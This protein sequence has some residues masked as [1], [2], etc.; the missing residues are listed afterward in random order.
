MRNKLVFFATSFA[1][2]WV[3][4]AI[5]LPAGWLLGALLTGII[6]S[7]F[8]EKLIF[9][10]ELFT[11][12]LALVG[13]VIGFMVVP[14]EVWEY[15]TLLPAFLLTLTLTLIGGI[16]L[17]K[18]F[19]KWTKL[20]GNTA[21]FC[22]LPGGASEVIALSERYQADQRIVAAFHT[23]RITLFVFSV[24]L[25]V[26]IGTQS[27]GVDLVERQ[28]ELTWDI[29]LVGL[30][31]LLAVGVFFVSRFL[32]FPGAPMFLAIILG[33]SVHQWI[34]PSYSMPNIVMGV[35]Q[36]LIGS[37]IGMRFDRSTLNE[38]K[39]IGK[40]SIVTLALYIAM[41]LGLAF[42]FFILSPLPFYTTLLAIV[43]AG[44][45]E[46][47]STAA[48]LEMDATVVATLQM[49]RVLALFLALPFLIRWFAQKPA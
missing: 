48:T 44:A 15:R 9:R 34:V 21:F 49:L 47:A 46:M 43:P 23:A 3:M 4:Q 25:I 41:S 2:G 13:I 10:S 33:F 6:W 30:A 42:T 39:R 45:A 11:L 37:V 29:A 40:P 27:S 17:G 31:F 14:E 16:A 26:G 36:V 19:G 1:V 18:F 20:S 22:C 5:G 12:S 35:A 38:L 32:A 24:P 8:I 7:F 28:Q